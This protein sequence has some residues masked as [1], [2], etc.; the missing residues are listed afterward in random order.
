VELD[1]GDGRT[2]VLIVEDVHWADDATVDAL[3]YLV[4]R[5]DGLRCLLIL[6]FRA[7]EVSPDHPL[8]RLLGAL[9]T[10]P[11]TRLNLAPLSRRAVEALGAGPRAADVHTA[12]A[13]NPFFVTEVLAS[14][15]FDVPT[16]VVDAV[17]ARVRRLPTPTRQALEQLAV[18]PSH[19]E[20]WLVD[21]LLG[22]PDALADAEQSGILE[23][24]PHG[25]AFRHDLAR[26]AL[27]R[28][29]P[30]VRQVGLHRAEVGVLLTRES[31]DL[32]RLVHHAM[33]GR[34]HATVLAY[35]PA[36]AREAAQ[37]GSHREA[38]HHYEHVIGLKNPRLGLML[39][40]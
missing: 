12:T 25:F 31:V 2:A 30:M 32:S 23:V 24:D 18:M 13:G 5:L 40:V 39:P 11:V 35:G 21:A 16:T 6:T 9:A 33:A 26:R 29:V 28:S 14:P 27:L 1:P 20:P 36:A 3:R 4:P 8:R 22:G 10:A 17:V 19:V 34:D 15:D 7:D 37:S 38:L